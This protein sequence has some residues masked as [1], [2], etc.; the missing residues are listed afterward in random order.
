MPFNPVLLGILL[1][2]IGAIFFALLWGMLRLIPR[3]RA[4]RTVPSAASQPKAGGPEN[5]V[6]IVQL[7]GR[8]EY[9]NA[10]ARQ[11]FNLREGEQPSLEMLSNRIRSSEEFLKICAAEG[12]ARFS[13]NGRP[14]ECKSYAVPGP[15]PSLLVAMNR[16]E[17]TTGAGMSEDGSLTALKILTDFDRSIS[18]SLDFPATVQAILENVEQLVPVDALEVKL[19]D[20]EQ[21]GLTSYRFVTGPRSGR[22]LERGLLQPPAGYTSFLV[23]NRTPLYLP[24][25]RSPGDEALKPFAEQTA[26]RSFVG[27]PLMVNQDL[28]GTLEAALTGA[29]VYSPEDFEVL[30]LV[31]GPAA[32]ALRNASLLEKEQR[33][34]VELS[35]LAELARVLG[36]ARDSSDLFTHL[37]QSLAP[38]FDVKTL[39]FLLYNE[40]KRALEAQ[41][42]FTGM[43]PQVV[44]L[45]HVP[46]PVG[47]PAEER[48][49]KQVTLTT[50]NAME[51]EVWREIGF[52]DYARA[53]SW[54]DS[55]LVPLVSSG[56][57]LGYLQIA[58]HNNPE[59][60]FSAEEMRLLNIVA[61]QT[62]PIIDNVTLVH[63]ARQRTQRAETLRRIVS[64]AAS[65]AT[66]DEVLRY[67]VQ[68]MA[69]LLQAD[70]GA[71]FLL[72]E[73]RGVLRLHDESLFG[74]TPDSADPLRH[75]FVDETQ[76]HFSVTGSRH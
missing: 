28:V 38:L 57:P 61:N 29:E 66:L 1:L 17:I 58:N 64:L 23:Q 60:A 45:Y 33:R 53:A 72:D 27:L 12:Q 47:S 48:F 32:V 36:L 63:Q 5:A 69:R 13:L 35:G 46:L 62:A 75:L 39:G 65:S 34:A 52:Q 8:V 54:R 3:L 76:F 19:W 40:N 4:G 70:L 67:T 9:V 31:S 50:Q 16:P 18:V 7:G 25:A 37:V 26:T 73:S 6:I 20:A 22:R 55:A 15:V 74:L 68:E 41:V 30:Q 49:L 10:A 11:W 56:R 2:L 59:A 14:L 24:D 51:D 42:P 44:N 43:P 71:L 21:E